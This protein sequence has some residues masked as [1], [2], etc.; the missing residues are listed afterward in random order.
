MEKIGFA[1]LPGLVQFSCFATIFLG[2]IL[3]AELIIDRHGYDH[4][5]PFYRVGNLCP[6]DLAV[7]LVLIVTW[8][9]LRRR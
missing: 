9:N 8:L 3:F 7:V 5:L 6:Y 1:T 2:W 4:Y